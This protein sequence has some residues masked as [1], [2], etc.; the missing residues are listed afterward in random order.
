MKVRVYNDGKLQHKEA[1][2]GSMITIPPDGYVEMHRDDAVQFLGQF[3]PMRRGGD[4]VQLEETFKKL[5]IEQIKGLK[6]T[7]KAKASLICPVC[8]FEAESQAGLDAHMK[9]KHSH[10]QVKEE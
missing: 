7:A 3:Y 1:F 4:G 8:G 5:R 2:K 9:S 10:L 6:K